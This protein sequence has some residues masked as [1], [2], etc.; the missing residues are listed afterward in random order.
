MK[1]NWEMLLGLALDWVSSV[2]GLRLYTPVFMVVL[3]RLQNHFDGR[4]MCR[5]RS[6]VMHHSRSQPA[7]FGSGS[8]QPAF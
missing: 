2:A 6:I 1:K 8:A 7:C 4:R 3:K 5:R